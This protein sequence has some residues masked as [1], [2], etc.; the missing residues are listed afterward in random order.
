MEQGSK[1]GLAWDAKKSCDSHTVSKAGERERI[2]LAWIRPRLLDRKAGI[3]QQGAERF[4][5]E[6]IAV[7]GMDGFKGRELNAKLRGRDIYAL[8]ARALQVHLDAGLHAIP[9]GPMPV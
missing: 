4:P 2:P 9:A 1:S 7:L 5:G 6:F 8:I 3:I